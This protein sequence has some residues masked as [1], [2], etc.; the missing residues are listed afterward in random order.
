MEVR[1]Q[2]F[3]SSTFRD[4]AEERR[5]VMQA[6]LE[7]DCIPAGMELFPASNDS[8]IR[9]IKDVIEQSDYYIVIVGGRYGSTGTDGVSFTE[10]EYDYAVS[11]GK[12]VLGF[13]HGRA[14]S[15]PAEDSEP[16]PTAR[17][18]L[19]NFRKKVEK[20]HCK[21]WTSA[22]ELG[23][24]VSRSL[25][26]ERKRNPMPGWVRSGSLG[27]P[28]VLERLVALQ[29]ENERLTSQVGNLLGGILPGTE[30]LEHGEDVVD[31]VITYR[32][33]YSSPVETFGAES[34]WDEVIRVIGPLMLQESSEK[35]IFGR[36][37]YY[38][39]DIGI[40]KE[41]TAISFQATLSA[42]TASS[43]LVQLIALRLVE[44]GLR[45]RGLQ[46]K[47]SYWKLTTYGERYLTQLRARRRIQA[48]ESPR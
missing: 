3:V 18:R 48:E 10:L 4:L 24:V 23:G 26:Q 40:L 36:L 15:I 21:Y 12:P 14:G 37:A 11:A 2:V 41:R 28:D 34:S 7:L 31:L 46:D 38:V 44:K 43:V 5:E 42:E 45:K 8:A 1:H 30:Q 17:N 6:L 25:V 47:E 29:E 16:E 27:G 9:L 33:N 32:Y 13:L 22:A 19:D 39:V 20:H 35:K